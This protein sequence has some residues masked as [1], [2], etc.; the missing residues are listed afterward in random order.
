MIRKNIYNG[1]NLNIIPSEKFKTN[2]MSVNFI[3]PLEKETAYLTALVPKILARGS[4]KYPDMAKISERLEYLYASGISPVYAKRAQSIVVGFAA[5]FIKDSF[6]GNGESLLE[7]V[8]E[9][10]FDII[11]APVT[12]NGAFVKAYTESEKIDLI[13]MIDS[14]INNK[15]AYA[16][17]KCTE[18]MFG[19]HPYGCSELGTVLQVKNTDEKRVYQRY[20]EIIK[21]APVE[22]FFNGE[23][24][25]EKLSE[26]IKKYVPEESGRNT[27]FPGRE[28]LDGSVIKVNEYEEAMPVAQGKLVM[29]LRMGGINVNSDDSAAFA[30]FNEIFGG[31]PSSKLF[32][33]VREAMSLCYY[34][35]SMP[36]MFMSAMFISSGIESEN[37]EKAKNAILL[38]LEQMKNE[39][40][41]E[42]DI[43]DAKRSLVNN[44]KELDD[45]AHTLCM[46]YLSRIITDNCSSPEQTISKI[47][48]VTKQDIVNAAKKVEL[49]TVYFIRGTGKEGEDE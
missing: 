26:I 43:D 41:T 18:K 33:N 3:V 28:F 24:D 8:C 12:E 17:E 31:S 20:L 37:L 30:V 49:D 34:C 38:Q 13:N 44:Y 27:V 7:S 10:L 15:A 45:G 16:K 2:Y 6:L 11:F 35:R 48:K 9:V 40:F 22:V 14:K 4:K 21:K 23:C 36:D 25:E 29:G 39:D 1:V 32:M 46:W 5:D 47:M 19:E 42:E